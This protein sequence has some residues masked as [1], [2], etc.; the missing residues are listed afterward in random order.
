MKKFLLTLFF[1]TL[2]FNS[3]SKVSLQCQVRYMEYGHWTEYQAVYVTFGSAKE[4]GI[5]DA[6]RN[7]YA[8]FTIGRETFYVRGEMGCGTLIVNEECLS[9]FTKNLDGRDQGNNKWSICFRQK[10]NQ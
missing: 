8:T 6:A 4:L 9:T 7:L 5:D 1:T 3:F 10:C 2:I